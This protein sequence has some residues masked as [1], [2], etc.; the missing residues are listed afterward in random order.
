METR[1]GFTLVKKVR[2]SKPDETNTDYSS[3]FRKCC[4]WSTNGG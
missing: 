3:A 2:Q 1:V 4:A